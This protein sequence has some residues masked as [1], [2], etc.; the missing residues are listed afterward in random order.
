MPSRLNKYLQP[1]TAHRHARIHGV[2]MSF[3]TH[4]SSPEANHCRF[5]FITTYVL[6]QDVTRAIIWDAE[7]C[8]RDWLRL[9]PVVVPAIGIVVTC[10]HLHCGIFQRWGWTIFPT[11]WR[12]VRH[13]TTIRRLSPWHVQKS[14]INRRSIDGA[15]ESHSLRTPLCVIPSHQLCPTG[16]SYPPCRQI[17]ALRELRIWREHNFCHDVEAIGLSWYIY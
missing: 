13:L 10:L 6:R 7:V 8:I 2:T 3:G 17:A 15:M 4:S 9:R 1:P 5:S 11:S 16:Y 14:E 12:Q